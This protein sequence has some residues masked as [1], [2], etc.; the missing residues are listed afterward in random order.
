MSKELKIN[1]CNTCSWT[2]SNK[3]SGRKMRKYCDNC[4]E[5]KQEEFNRKVIQQSKG[6]KLS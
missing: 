5:D 2:Y 1:N 4:K 3:G 6:E